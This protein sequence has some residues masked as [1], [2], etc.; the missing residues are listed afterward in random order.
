MVAEQVVNKLQVSFM[1][2]LSTLEKEI[3]LLKDLNQKNLM[4]SSDMKTLKKIMMNQFFF[5][6]CLKLN[7]NKEF[8]IIQS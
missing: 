4:A 7:I 5:Y 8:L 6:Y 2:K 3:G 1:E